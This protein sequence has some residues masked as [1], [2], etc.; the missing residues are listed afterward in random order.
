MT[1]VGMAEKLAERAEHQ[2][3]FRMIEA[4]EKH[5]PCTMD[6]CRGIAVLT[7]EVGEAAE[8]ALNATRT[9]VSTENKLKYLRHMRYELE[10]VAGYAILLRCAMDD[11]IKEVDGG[12]K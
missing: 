5:G 6:P 11:L 1:A 8:Q 12:A 9:N 2:V 10:Q 3:Q 4:L 7:E